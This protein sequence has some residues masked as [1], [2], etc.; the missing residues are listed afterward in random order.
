VDGICAYGGVRA[1]PAR[2]DLRLFVENMA[3]LDGGRVAELLQ[4]KLVRV[5]L[6]GGPGHINAE[7][8]MRIRH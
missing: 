4:S 7:T 8:A 6:C 1:Q 2:E 5:S 3:S